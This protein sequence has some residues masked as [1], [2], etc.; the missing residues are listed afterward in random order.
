[1][2]MGVQT[3]QVRT[4]VLPAQQQQGLLQLKSAPNCPSHSHSKA[5]IAAALTA[6]RATSSH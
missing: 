5:A 3:K 6:L 2:H 4:I 1:M